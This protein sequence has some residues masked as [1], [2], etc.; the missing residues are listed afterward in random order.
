MAVVMLVGMSGSAAAQDR[1]LQEARDPVS[2]AA[3]RVYRTG[4]GPGIEVR[5]DTL[6]LRKQLN[7]NRIVTSISGGKETLVIDIAEGAIRVHGTRG[8]ATGTADDQAGLARAKKLVAESPLA[9]KAAGL[10]GKMGLGDASAVAPLL[11]T[12]RAFLL[13]AADDQSGV[14]GLREWLRGLRARAQVIKVGQKTPTE[15]W[16]AYG[17]EL[18]AAYDEFNDCM[19]SIK[20]WDPFF[21]VQ[22][23]EVTYEVRILGAFA[24]YLDC[25][26]ILEP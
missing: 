19:D 13:A 25:V 15:C 3:V 9:A 16:K 22:R 2:G 20:W 23:C 8:S 6:T 1:L 14:H 11:L 24:W 7:G 12:T 5:T 10:I 4:A 17:D 26:K 18:L 21:P